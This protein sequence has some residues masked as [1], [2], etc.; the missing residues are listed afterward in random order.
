MRCRLKP[1][2]GAAAEWTGAA[3]EWTGAAAEWTGAAAWRTGADWQSTPAK[4]AIAADM[5]ERIILKRK[6]C[7]K[8]MDE[9]RSRTKDG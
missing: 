8:A 1:G 3:A 9:V 6:L 4:R 5:D 7:K 2:T